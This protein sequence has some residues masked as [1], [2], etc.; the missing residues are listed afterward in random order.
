MSII[1]TRLFSRAPPK[2]KHAGSPL[3]LMLQH[4]QEIYGDTD[5][6]RGFQQDQQ[7]NLL[8]AT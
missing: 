7:I 1:R 6:I 8:A 3:L 2:K 5:P 4:L